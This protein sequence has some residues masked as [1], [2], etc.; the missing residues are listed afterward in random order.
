V[1]FLLTGFGDELKPKVADI[2]YLIV[3]SYR[4]A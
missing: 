2:G 4:W 1:G 3:E